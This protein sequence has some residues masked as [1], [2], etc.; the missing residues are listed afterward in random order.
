VHA[1]A[2]AAVAT[3]ARACAVLAWGA[4]PLEPPGGPRPGSSVTGP[5]PL[6][7][8]ALPAC[9]LYFS[10]KARI[11]VPKSAFVLNRNDGLITVCPD[12]PP[13][14]VSMTSF[15]VHG[16]VIVPCTPV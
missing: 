16:P 4:T 7:L 10:R 8:M 3:A 1:K 11:Q 6:R 2:R 14:V 5:W 13:L 12:A 9:L 15:V